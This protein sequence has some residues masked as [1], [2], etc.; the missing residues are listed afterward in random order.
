MTQGSESWTSL[1]VIK[2]QST[3]ECITK[4]WSD[5]RGFCNYWTSGVRF[6]RIWGCDF[7]VAGTDCNDGIGGGRCVGAG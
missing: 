1:F 4:A 3:S 2:C 5:V 6:V 7:C